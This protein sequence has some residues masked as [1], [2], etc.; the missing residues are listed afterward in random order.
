M[1]FL[2]HRLIVQS[3]IIFYSDI[4]KIIVFRSS[5]KLFITEFKQKKQKKL[6]SKEENFNFDSKLKEKNILIQDANLT[7]NEKDFIEIN[8]KNLNPLRYQFICDNLPEAKKE[9][10]NE[11]M[12]EIETQ[13]NKKEN[14]KENNPFVIDEKHGE[15]MKTIDDKLQNFSTNL[16]V[17]TKNN[18]YSLEK[19]N[20]EL[21]VMK[22][23]KLCILFIF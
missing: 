3:K 18:D 19:I 7:K 12:L 21:Y 14:I 20:E 9:R 16:Q 1:S 17:E 15:L 23:L 13:N 11:L 8:K 2:K 22:F 10:L 5:K 6:I 4:K